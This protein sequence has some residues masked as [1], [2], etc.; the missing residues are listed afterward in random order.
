MMMEHEGPRFIETSVI[1][2]GAVYAVFLALVVAL[3][4]GLL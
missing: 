1:V 4:A 2:L 3:S